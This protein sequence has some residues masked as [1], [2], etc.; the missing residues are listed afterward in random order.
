MSN[1]THYIYALTDPAMTEVKYIGRTKNPAKRL[2]DHCSRKNSWALWQWIAANKPAKPQMIVLEECSEENAEEREHF[3][4]EVYKAT[5]AN[6]LNH[7][8]VNTKQRVNEA[9]HG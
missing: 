9:Y 4:I 6:L 7:F 1:K 2:K 3:W 8:G 5:G